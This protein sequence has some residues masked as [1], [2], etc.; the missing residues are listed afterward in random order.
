M[1]AKIH[2]FKGHHSVGRV[3]GKSGRSA[4]LQLFY[5]RS[6]KGKGFRLAVVVSKKVAK[7]AV[8]RNRIRRR[9]YEAVRANNL[10]KDSHCDAVIV[11]RSAVVASMPA[12]ELLLEITTLCEQARAYGAA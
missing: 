10:L 2:R 11:V 5:A 4:N 12:D 3:R 7:S 1:I 6:P 8:V 9:L